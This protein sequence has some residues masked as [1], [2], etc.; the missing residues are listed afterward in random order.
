MDCGVANYLDLSLHAFEAECRT[1]H[2]WGGEVVSYDHSVAVAKAIHLIRDPFDNIVGRMH[3]GSAHQQS[4][5]EA[6]FNHSQQ[7]LEEWCQ[8]LDDKYQDQDEAA[9]ALDMDLPCRAEWY[10]Y[11]QWHN[12]A[13][14]V[15]DKIPQVLHVY[16]D[17]YTTNYDASVKQLLAFL[18][19]EARHKPL[20]FQSNKTYL[21]YFSTHHRQQAARFAQR[22]AS[23]KSWKLL[24]HYFEPHLTTGSSTQRERPLDDDDQVATDRDSDE[25]EHSSESAA[26]NFTYNERSEVV[27][28][29]NCS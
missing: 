5:G 8:Y 17:N 28:S 29:D 6:G 3:L 13:A 2:A 14:E 27:R 25:N 24:A 11:I 7:G 18:E 15:T 12:L 19:L 16:Y 4:R 10:R 9:H 23:E 21:E 26:L 22:F 1:G 20:F